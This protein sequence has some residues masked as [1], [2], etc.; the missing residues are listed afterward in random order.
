MVTAQ[1]ITVCHD[2]NEACPLFFGAGERLHWSFPDPS[3]AAGNE[4][5]RLAVY[6]SVRD[7]ISARIQSDLLRAD[8]AA[9]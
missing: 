8:S 4:E 1:N 6:R 2:A 5:E 3:K 9:S 7:A